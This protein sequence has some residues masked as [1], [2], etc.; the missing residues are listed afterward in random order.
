MIWLPQTRPSQEQ[1]NGRKWWFVGEWVGVRK[2]GE[3]IQRWSL[4]KQDRHFWIIQAL[5]G[6]KSCLHG[7]RFWQQQLW[8]KWSL[9]ATIKNQQTT[10]MIEK[11]DL[12]LK[13]WASRVC[14]V[15]FWGQELHLTALCL[16][17]WDSSAW[18]GAFS[19][20]PLHC[21]WTPPSHLG[22]VKL[23]I[24]SLQTYRFCWDFEL[25]LILPS[26]LVG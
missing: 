23:R 17:L 13:H 16:G 6:T 11:E 9:T 25:V 24:L 5:T 8:S 3:T 21:L 7:Q 18:G 12:C 14:G 1:L 10:Q 20:V 4:S 2:K 26:K 15:S 19:S 22:Y